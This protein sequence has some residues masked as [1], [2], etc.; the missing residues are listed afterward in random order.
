MSGRVEELNIKLNL[1]SDQV[2]MLGNWLLQNM[3]GG[4]FLNSRDIG[5]AGGI[6]GFLFSLFIMN[7]I[8]LQRIKCDLWF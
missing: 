7:T 4:L 3:Q 5:M 8:K 2:K 6:L 1:C